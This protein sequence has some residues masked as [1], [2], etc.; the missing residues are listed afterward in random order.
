MVNR[1]PIANLLIDRN[2]KCLINLDREEKDSLSII[3]KVRGEIGTSN[4]F[5]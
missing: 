5:I 1:T 2:E 4:F 3:I